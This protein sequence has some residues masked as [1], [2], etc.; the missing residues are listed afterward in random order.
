MQWHWKQHRNAAM[1]CDL[2]PQSFKEKNLLVKHMQKLHLKQSFECSKCS[3]RSYVKGDLKSHMLCHNLKTCK[4]CSKVFTNLPSHLRTHIMI[5]CQFCSRLYPKTSIAL[6]LQKH[7]SK[8][9]DSQLIHLSCYVDRSN[10]FDRI[11][12]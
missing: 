2:C 3:Y 8:Y 11:K 5:K 9:K 7:A 10:V 1:L 4:I 6:H 12:F